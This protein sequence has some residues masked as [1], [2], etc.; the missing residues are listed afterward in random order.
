MK[1]SYFP[2]TLVVGNRPSSRRKLFPSV[3]D[4]GLAGHV[5]A[6]QIRIKNL[7]Q[8]GALPWSYPYLQILEA[9]KPTLVMVCTLPQGI[10]GR[11]PA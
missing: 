3:F 8:N 4:A 11:I 9:S 7:T 10:A 6:L 1:F 2:R 5:V